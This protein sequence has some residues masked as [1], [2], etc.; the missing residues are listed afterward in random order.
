MIERILE[1]VSNGPFADDGIK[2]KVGIYLCHRYS[3]AKLRDIGSHFEMKDAAVS[4]ASKRLAQQIDKDKALDKA[5][6][7]IEEKL[8]MSYVET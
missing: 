7:K 3:G 2:K 6:K 5:L 1:V 4:Q 8:R